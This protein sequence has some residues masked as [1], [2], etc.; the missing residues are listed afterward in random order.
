[1]FELNWYNTDDNNINFYHTF[2]VTENNKR[3][4][5]PNKASYCIRGAWDHNPEYENIKNNLTFLQG[6]TVL[7]IGC[8]EGFFTL[9][10]DDLGTKV[11]SMDCYNKTT[12]K[13]AWKLFNYHGEFIHEN[14]YQLGN[15]YDDYDYVWFSDVLVHL[16]NPLYALSN[17]RKVARKG[18]LLGV[19]ATDEITP[20]ESVW[21]EY[22]ENREVLPMMYQPTINGEESIYFWLIPSRTVVSILN[23]FFNNTKRIFTYVA[24]I[25]SN[26][27]ERKIDVYLAETDNT[28]DNR[29]FLELNWKKED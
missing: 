24:G 4:H 8:Q 21:E 25:D 6:Q 7:D 19:D 16:E 29:G 13:F 10:L 27:K 26:G 18:I 23:R 15:S 9:L 1:M 20:M 12:R 28:L 11:T 22:S 5:D 3:T 14:V 17:I 2:Y